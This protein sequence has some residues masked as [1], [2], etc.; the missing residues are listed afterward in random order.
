MVFKYRTRMLTP[1]AAK[2]ERDLLGHLAVE[3]IPRL[4]ESLERRRE[5]AKFA[6]KQQRDAALQAANVTTD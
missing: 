3:E 1:P 4:Q 5:V 2:C 6:T